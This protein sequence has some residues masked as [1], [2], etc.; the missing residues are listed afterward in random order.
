[1][2][3]TP[4][5]VRRNHGILRNCRKK[6]LESITF[7]LVTEEKNVFKKGKYVCVIPFEKIFNVALEVHIDVDHGDRHKVMHK[8]KTKYE[9][10]R[11][12]IKNL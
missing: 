12:I 10:G 1:M 3:I 8:L 5:K 6:K 7:Y 11:N 2:I 4:I 9:V